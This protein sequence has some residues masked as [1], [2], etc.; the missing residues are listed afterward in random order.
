M[1]HI[2]YD[3]Q[4]TNWGGAIAE[5]ITGGM[6]MALKSKAM[7]QGLEKDKIE[8]DRE[9]KEEA[10]R[11]D[12]QKAYET[13]AK[14]METAP[15]VP[16]EYKP[17]PIPDPKLS[18]I[19][20]GS[21][22]RSPDTAIRQ[23][24][25]E[26]SLIKKA[27]DEAVKSNQKLRDDALAYRHQAKAD[28]LS[29]SHNAFIKHGFPEKAQAL[30]EHYLDSVTKLY[31]VSPKAALK[32]WN[33][34]YLK[35]SYGELSEKDI[36]SDKEYDFMTIGK[37]KDGLIKFNKAQGTWSVEKEPKREAP[38]TREVQRGTQTVT[39]EWDEESGTWRVVGKGP[40][41]KAGE[42]EGDGS[43]SG[44]KVKW[45]ASDVESFY[46][47][48]KK[49]ITNPETGE[50]LPGWEGYLNNIPHYRTMDLK[51]V[52]SGKMKPGETPMNIFN[53]SNALGGGGAAPANKGERRP[54]ADFDTSKKAPAKKETKAA[55]AKPAQSASQDSEDSGFTGYF[56]RKAKEEMENRK[57]NPS[58]VNQI[59]RDANRR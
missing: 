30:E 12:I 33:S 32:A 50:A 26:V 56:K 9:K 4:L 22:A 39:E 49:D 6:N 37:N 23:A 25:H 47:K 8:L 1:A 34:S 59:Y 44:K 3:P 35:D 11:T 57:K 31:R 53:I 13:F 55:P 24:V 42:G 36:K 54:L 46:D 15:P 16:D 10:A 41:W 52:N 40:K 38:K 21:D 51:T 14:K 45:K 28:L 19:T 48:L 2:Y 27:E 43:G 29:A 58:I 20:Q 7:M 17:K 5:G 18:E